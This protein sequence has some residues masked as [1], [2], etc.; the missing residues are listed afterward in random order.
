MIISALL[1]VLYPIAIQVK[2]GGLWYVL[3]PLTKIAFWLDVLANY[4]EWAFVF[5]WPKK[6]D[7]T[8]SKRLR[9]MAEY[10]PHES[11]RQFAKMVQ[12]YLDAMEH[13]GKH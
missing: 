4:T 11:Q 2:R 9:W 10:A 1:L 3:F 13:D 12:V 8:I 5:G 7:Y 6:G